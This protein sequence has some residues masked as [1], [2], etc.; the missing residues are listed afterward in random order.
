MRKAIFGKV[1]KKLGNNLKQLISGGAKLDVEVGE[2][3]ER[4]GFYV[5]E[6]YGLTET[7][8]IIAVATIKERKLGTVGKLLPRTE[9]KIVEEEIWVKGPQVMKGYYKKPDKTKKIS[10]PRAPKSKTLDIPR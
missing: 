2:I 9:V 5:T 3:F 1:H 4:L 8:P 10:T 6:G 7:S